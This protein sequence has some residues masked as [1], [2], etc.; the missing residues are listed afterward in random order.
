MSSFVESKLRFQDLN[1]A[2]IEKNGKPNPI[3]NH[4]LVG[5]IYVRITRSGSISENTEIPYVMEPEAELLASF[6]RGRSIKSTI[7]TEAP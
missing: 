6:G 5:N 3:L 4:R 7:P 2:W 1:L